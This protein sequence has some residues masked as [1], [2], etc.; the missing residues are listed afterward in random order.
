MTKLM[1]LSYPPH[2]KVNNVF[3]IS[4][5][6]KYVPD[7]NHILDDELPLVSKDRTLNIAPK[8]VLQTRMRNLRNRTLNKYLVK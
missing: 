8:R 5:L 2:I 6:K 1:N 7:A 3:H 4:L